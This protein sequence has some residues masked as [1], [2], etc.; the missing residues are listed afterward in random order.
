MIGLP[1][2]C[3][4]VTTSVNHDIPIASVKQVCNNFFKHDIPIDGQSNFVTT[5]ANH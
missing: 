5:S 3:K 4:F 1:G 2:K